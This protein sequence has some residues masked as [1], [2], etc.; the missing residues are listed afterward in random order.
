MKEFAAAIGALAVCLV[1]GTAHACEQY[2]ALDAADA[3]QALSTLKDAKSDSMTRVLA[4]NALAC[5]TI[6][7][8]RQVAM[9]EALKID[10]PIVKGSVLLE[11]LLQRDAILVELI[12]SS[13]LSRDAKAFAEQNN[14]SLVYKLGFKDPVAGCITLIYS[15]NECRKDSM[16]KLNGDSVDLYSGNLYG[17]FTLQPDNTLRGYIKPNNRTAQIPARIGLF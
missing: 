17:K 1:V 4:F 13:A 7:A 10:D 8:V 5:A 6:P 3:Q 11:I 9:K 15:T 12:P 16:I 2:K 14:N